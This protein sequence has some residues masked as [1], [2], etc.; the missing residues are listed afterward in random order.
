MIKML[1]DISNN[2]TMLCVEI[3]AKQGMLIFWL[4]EHLVYGLSQIATVLAPAQ[5]ISR[6]ISVR[7][8]G[9]SPALTVPAWPPHWGS[10]PTCPTP[11]W[12]LGPAPMDAHGIP[13]CHR[14]PESPTTSAL[15]GEQRGCFYRRPKMVFPFSCT[16]KQHLPGSLPE[17]INLVGNTHNIQF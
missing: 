10:V 15:Q 7:A 17:N 3:P 4:D 1:Q 5:S 9:A 14:P 2:T 11:S 8:P 6:C 13:C 12:L 16:W